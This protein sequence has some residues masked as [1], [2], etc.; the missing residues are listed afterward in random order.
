MQYRCSFI[1][2]RKGLMDYQGL[3]QKD[4]TNKIFT[5]TFKKLS[6]H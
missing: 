6:F 2:L 5:V 1:F 3:Q 4:E